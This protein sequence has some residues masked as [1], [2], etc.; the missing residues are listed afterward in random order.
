MFLFPPQTVT[1][2][3]YPAQQ[4]VVCLFPLTGISQVVAMAASIDG[5]AIEDTNTAIT[6]RTQEP[7]TL[8]AKMA[9][10]PFQGNGILFSFPFVATQWLGAIVE[11]DEASFGPYMRASF[12]ASSP[13]KLWI[14]S[15]RR[16]LHWRRLSKFSSFFRASASWASRST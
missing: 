4:S 15:S 14:C 11:N 5:T 6:A 9:G 10:C 16:A 13:L 3:L 1:N 7:W 12:A 8:S 2:F